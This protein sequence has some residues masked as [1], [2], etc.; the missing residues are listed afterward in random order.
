M[1]FR[2]LIEMDVSQT[3]A[4]TMKR[5]GFKLEPDGSG[6]KVIVPNTVTVTRRKVKVHFDYPES[7]GTD[8]YSQEPEVAHGRV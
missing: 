1:K 5:N 2:V 3:M 7:K 4:D 8:E 6:M